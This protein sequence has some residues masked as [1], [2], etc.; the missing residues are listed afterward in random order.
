MYN[1]SSIWEH[2]PADSMP[3]LMKFYW[4]LIIA[5]IVHQYP[6]MYF[7]RV[8]NVSKFDTFTMDMSI[9]TNDRF[10]NTIFG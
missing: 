10:A 7:M 3:M 2:T 1:L 4:I 6:E 9:Q 5:F 8:K